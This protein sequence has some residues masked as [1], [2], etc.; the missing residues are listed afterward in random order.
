MVNEVDLESGGKVG[1][2]VRCERANL[3]DKLLDILGY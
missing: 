2:M 3:V 1:V